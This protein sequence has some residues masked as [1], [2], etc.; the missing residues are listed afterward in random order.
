VSA[1]AGPMEARPVGQGMEGA[2]TPMTD[3][4]SVTRKILIKGR[5]TAMQRRIIVP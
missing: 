4:S 3:A 1:C 5:S 2:H